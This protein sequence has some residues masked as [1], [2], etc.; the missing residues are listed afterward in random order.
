VLDEVRGRLDASLPF[1]LIRT[2]SWPYGRKRRGLGYQSLIN[3]LLLAK[4]VSRQRSA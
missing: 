3:E 2:F 4:H 1:E